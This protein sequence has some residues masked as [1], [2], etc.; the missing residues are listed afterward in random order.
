MLGSLR[1]TRLQDRGKDGKRCRLLLCQLGNS[2]E[3]RKTTHS[4][5]ED[6][7]D[8]LGNRPREEGN[9]NRQQRN[10]SQLRVGTHLMF[11]YIFLATQRQVDA[12]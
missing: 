1:R 12:G 6:V 10:Q 3:S 7:C 8:N 5:V 9:L 2:E 11:L 4:R